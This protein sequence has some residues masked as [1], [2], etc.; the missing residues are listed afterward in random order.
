MRKTI[1]ELSNSGQI[2]WKDVL[3]SF[4][5]AGTIVESIDGV[6]ASLAAAGKG[7]A[8][9]RFEL[10]NRL[11]QTQAQTTE[12]LEA[13]LTPA[14][15][16]RTF[17]RTSPDNP[18]ANSEIVWT[19]T[20][21]SVKLSYSEDFCSL[22]MSSTDAEL[23]N[24]VSDWFA[25]VTTDEEDAGTVYYLT[26]EQ[27]AL[28]FQRM[29][30]GGQE[31]ERGNYA[32]DVLTS[33]D[34]LVEELTCKKPKGRLAI[35]EGPPGTGKSYL[36]RGLLQDCSKKANLVIVPPSLVPV[37]VGPSGATLLLKFRA[38]NPTTPL[39]LILEDA[40]EVLAPR[41][42]GNLGGISGVLNIGD[43]IVGSTL[44]IRIV[45]TTNATQ[46]ELDAAVKRP[47]RLNVFQHVGKLTTAQCAEIYQRLTG[48]EMEFEK[49]L[50][51]A[52]VYQRAYDSGWK[53]V[54]TE[55]PRAMGF[56]NR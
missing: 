46:T 26:E 38:E 8:P 49:E 15:F 53:G 44:D 54:K 1:E 29:G 50:V 40:D 34:R 37:M 31:L 22:L 5:A 39:V 48:K 52:E 10:G 9:S 17:Q 13:M 14:G 19:A 43:G 7:P 2:T 41:S 36:L 23:C 16:V 45:A 55:A 33:Y 42:N 47:G 30:A 12:E 3:P 4:Y 21:G 20:T 56:G 51:L 25:E 27:G 24:Q 11:L 32:P 35:F 18:T 6:M 28:R